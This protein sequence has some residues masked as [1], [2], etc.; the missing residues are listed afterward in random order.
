[1]QQ[2][3]KNMNAGPIDTFVDVPLH[4]HSTAYNINKLLGNE[5]F[6]RLF[7]FAFVRNPW[8]IQFSLY[9]YI[10]GST[11]HNRHQEII[12]FKDFEHYLKH[13]YYK[14]LEKLSIEGKTPLDMQM[15]FV[16]DKNAKQLVSYVGRFEKINQ[17]FEYILNEIGFNPKPKLP[18]LNKFT[19]N[20]FRHNYTSQMVDWVNEMHTND[21]KYFG[22]T[23][24]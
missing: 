20:D 12:K 14:H 10:L 4:Y 8:D 21:I 22:Y 17:D 6:S 13:T 7:S 16:C 23:F 15:S 24:E 18:H 9:K 19:N 3:F 1:M 11:H 2:A 5:L